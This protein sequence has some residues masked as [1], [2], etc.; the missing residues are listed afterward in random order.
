MWLHCEWLVI[1]AKGRNTHFHAFVAVFCL[2]VEAQNIS[3]ASVEATTQAVVLIF[4]LVKKHVDVDIS[5][6]A[7]WATEV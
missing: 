1:F 2:F 6:K 4:F 3:F 7:T 5:H